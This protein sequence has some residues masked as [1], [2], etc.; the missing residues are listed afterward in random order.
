VGGDGKNAARDGVSGVGVRSGSSGGGEREGRREGAGGGV[1][2]CGTSE[3]A[4][5]G[6]EAATRAQ[7]EKISAQISQKGKGGAP[8]EFPGAN[9]EIVGDGSGGQ[10]LTER[11]CPPLVVTFSQLGIKS[12]FDETAQGEGGGPLLGNETDVMPLKKGFLG[13][14]A[15]KGFLGGA[16]GGIGGGEEGEGLEEVEDIDDMKVG[17]V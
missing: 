15:D 13:A 12:P 6:D 5:R 4:G 14:S 17:A 1:G 8:E 10:V 7:R 3:M 2:S 11:S 16:A 9:H